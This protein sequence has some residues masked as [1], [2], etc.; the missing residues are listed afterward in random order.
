MSGD[1]MPG[2]RGQC[3][4]CGRHSLF[5]AAGGYVT[6]GN[7]TCVD[8][9]FVA[10]LLEPQGTVSPGPYERDRIMIERIVNL[11]KHRHFTVGRDGSTR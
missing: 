8:P 1:P 11:Q 5:L 6:C 3:P 2:V 4:A 10:D 9:T 7:G